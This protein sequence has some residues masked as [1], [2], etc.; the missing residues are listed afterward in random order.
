MRL[1]LPG[2]EA[3]GKPGRLA[4][5]LPGTLVGFALGIIATL[6]FGP[7]LGEQA[8][9]WS[10]APA[11]F[12]PELGAQLGDD[13]SRIGGIRVAVTTGRVNG[14]GTDNAVIAWF[15][16]VPFELSDDPA[17]AFTPGSRTSSVLSGPGLPRTL[18]ELRRASVVLSLH[19]NHAEIGASWYCESASVEVRLEGSE[20]YT[21]YLTA[22]DVGWLSQDEPP[23]RSPAYALQ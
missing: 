9:Q 4:S 10:G 17:S 19:L 5:N 21:P 20:S 7:P 11:G 18:G 13:S 23:R 15:D 3:T 14:A 8:S 12:A 2:D 1:D 22:V 6:A 16:N